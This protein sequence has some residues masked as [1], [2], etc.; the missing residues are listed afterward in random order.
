MD[1]PAYS[2]DNTIKQIE[3]IEFDILGNRE[4]KER[5]ALGKDTSGTEVPD[6]H[7]DGEPK[8]GGLIDSRL[9]TTDNDI[10][11]LTCGLNATY[12]PGHFGH[13]DLAEKVFH[14]EYLDYIKKI[15]E[16]ICLKCSKLLLLY[17]DNNEI[18]EILKTKNGKARLAEVHNYVK[19]IKYCKNP[20]SNKLSGCGT[21]VSKIRVEIKKTTSIINIISEIDIEDKELSILEGKKSRTILTPEIIY[22]KLKNISNNDCNILGIDSKRSRPENMIHVIFPIP[23][24]QMRPST[25]GDFMGGATME[26]DLTHKL[27]DIV[28]ANYRIIKQKESTNENANKYN[29]DN[30]SL[31]EYQIATYINNQKLTPPKT[32][33]KG[34]P[35]KSIVLRIKSKEGRIRSNLMG[36]RVDHSARTVIT[37]DPTID[38]N[39][40]GV[41]IK[42]AKELTF[43]E[44][45]TPQ[46]IEHLTKLIRRGRDEYPGA[47]F[48]FPMSG[49]GNRIMPIDLR[50]R[51]EQIELRYGDIV[52]RHLIDGDIV[53]LN[54][55][56]TLHKQ[57]MMGH[58]IKV[59]NNP[60]LMTYRL[61]VAITTPYNADFD[62]D[63]MNIFVPQSIQTQ[64]ELEEIA[65]VKRQIITPS[66]SRTIIGIVQDGLLG[67]Y[68]LTST[69]IKIDWRNTM[70]IISYTSIE[71]L[72]ILKKGEEYTGHEIFSLIIPTAI[73]INKKEF[74]IKSGKLIEGKLDKTMLGSKKKNAIHQL[75]WDEYGA[76]ETKKFI[77][78]TQ[79][80]INN[81]NLYNGFTVG[82]GDID[83][84]EENKIQINNL[85]ETKEMKVNYMITEIENNPDLMEKNVFEFKIFS[86][87]NIIRD[88]ISKLIM[89]NLKSNN[90]FKIMINSGSKGDAT[91]MGQ[92]GGCVG[93]QAFEGNLISKKYNDRTIAYYHQNDDRAESRGLVKQSFVSGLEFPSFAYHLLTG[94]E[95]L[96]D[97]AIKTATTGYAQRRLV[98]SMEDLMIKY[99]GTV[100][101]AND[102]MIQLVYGDSGADTTKQYEYNIRMIE[103]GDNELSSKHKFTKEEL[104]NYKEYKENEEVYN[105]IKNMRDV[106]RINMF[107]AKSN[108]ITL[109]NTFMLPVNITRIID[110]NLDKKW[111]NSNIVEPSYVYKRIEEILQNEYTTV[112]CINKSEL[113]NKE[114]FKIRDENAIKTIFRTVLYD[115]LSPKRCCIEYQL[116]KNQFDIIIYEI[117]NNFNKNIV[118]PGEMI[119]IIGAQ[120]MGEPLTQMTLNAFHHSGIASMST[121]TQGVPRVQEILSATKK[122]KTPQLILYLTN[123]F[124]TNKEMAHK[125]ASH[126]KYTTLGDIRKKIDIYYDINPTKKGGIMETDNI[127]NIILNDKM[128]NIICQTNITTLP[129]LMRIE[130][131][132][133]KMIDKEV[134]L[135]EIKTK[136][137]NW[138]D[139]RFNEIKNMKKEEKKVLNKLISL[140]VLTNS[141]TDKQPVIHI[142]FNVKDIDKDKFNRETLNNF[143]NHIIDKFKLKGIEDIINIPAIIEE[144][145][146]QFNK[147]TNDIEYINQQ[148]I[149][150][151]GVNLTEIRYING[152]D[153]L[154][155]SC[156]DI[157]EVYNTFGIE[158]AR[159]KIMKELN[160]AYERGGHSV[161]Y[162]NLSLLVDI[163]T[164]NGTIMSIDRHGMNKSDTDPLSRASF[165]KSVE[166]LISASVFGETDYM[167]GVSSRIMAGLVIKGG[168]CFCDVLLDT[169]MIEKS[170]YTEDGDIYK[171]YNEITTNT[172]AS[173]ILNNDDDENIFIP[174]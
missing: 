68:N 156:N 4:I 115:I 173:D 62:G 82:Y 15:L 77:D 27:A 125:I 55:Q 108:F 104:K 83:I 5:S 1:T 112:I 111:D 58:I 155:S 81:Y 99:D 64:I 165:E 17:K 96:I 32:E 126:I 121:T 140:V 129:W 100:R 57:S 2:Y 124:K 136:L 131:N 141:D 113:K 44:V 145:M 114:S 74:K 43:P 65:D 110:N 13:M 101:T 162:Q 10:Q 48:V 76:D 95:G 134:T 9:G 33:Q 89:S 6:L 30:R 171:I 51:K 159:T 24:V 147:I 92:M 88:D 42:I 144:R 47:N 151:A 31:L 132:R 25:K 97:Q 26:D 66:T 84:S 52:E 137:C 160:N 11:C 118:Q 20:T 50:F 107:K 23:P 56:P 3:R 163:M 75:I 109:T 153:V 85:F 54:R 93:L 90:N 7:I 8:K 142:R 119:G 105:I 102:T 138:W 41:P 14:I 46:N 29:M 91:N 143:I 78:N 128:K 35:F 120:S 167:R 94:R 174:N 146:V 18:K 148:V 12:C 80:L 135:L 130:I 36:K 71:D 103:M 152:I 149:F 16:C 157:M 122:T 117:I 73:N 172:I 34:K 169:E 79:R 22:E 49:I 67:A 21:Q 70:N 106:I 59:I 150:T 87:L 127:K 168:T 45:V 158:I 69:N 60:D 40:L 86:E 164:N 28:K 63:E 98:K 161:N 38:N 39:Q 61:S 170:E 53:L 116:L 72:S 154:N 166:Q 19:N 123:E 37:S 133:E 139:K